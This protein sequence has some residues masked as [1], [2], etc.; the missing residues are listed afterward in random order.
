MKASAFAGL[1][2]AAIEAIVPVNVVHPG[3]VFHGVVDDEPPQA[4]DRAFCVSVS[5][6]YRALEAPTIAH[7]EFLLDFTVIVSYVDSPEM[8][9]RVMDDAE[10]IVDALYAL[11]D[12]TNVYKVTVQPGQL[13]AGRVEGT[14]EAQFAAQAQYQRD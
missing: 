2:V 9:P 14:V 12:G 3:D 7:L 10:L 6:P 13:L 1:V 5:L 8:G 11:I 4:V